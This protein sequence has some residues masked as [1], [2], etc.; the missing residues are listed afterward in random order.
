MFLFNNYK[1]FK[2]FLLKYIY[3]FVIIK[4]QWQ[5]GY[6]IYKNNINKR[7]KKWKKKGKKKIYIYIN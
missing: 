5:Q 7:K 1:S 3:I 2:Y 6:E 4:S